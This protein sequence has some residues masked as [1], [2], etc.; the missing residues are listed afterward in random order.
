MKFD[1]FHNPTFQTQTKAQMLYCHFF[2][3]G[4]NF[5]PVNLLLIL[6]HS[7]C[8][9]IKNDATQYFTIICTTISTTNATFIH[10]VYYDSE[11]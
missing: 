4:Y 10:L 9:L 8:C 11:T 7:N 5:V 1:C 3:I 6:S 2:F